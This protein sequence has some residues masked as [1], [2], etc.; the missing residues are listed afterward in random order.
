[1]KGFNLNQCA[2]RGSSGTKVSSECAHKKLK[3]DE[4]FTTSFSNGSLIVDI[5]QRGDMNQKLHNGGASPGRQ[6]GVVGDEVST[7]SKF[8]KFKLK[9]GGVTRTI[10]AK[11][12]CHATSGNGSSTKIAEIS[13]STRPLPKPILQDDFDEGGSPLDKSCGMQGIPWK[14]FSR[15]DFNHLN[16]IPTGKMRDKNVSRKQAEKSDQVR[17]NK[18][19]SRKC[20]FN[21]EFDDDDDEIRYLEKLRTSK[22]AAVS[23]DAVQESG[24]KEQSRTKD[25][26]VANHESAKAFGPSR[27]D[28]D[29]K[30]A[31]LDRVRED[32]D[33][34]EEKIMH[35]GEPECKQKRTGKDVINSP[36]ESKKGI[37]LSMRQRALV[38]GKGFSSVA[39]GNSIEFPNGLPP[40]PS[41]RKKEKL[42]E[43]EQQLKKAETAERRRMQREKAAR[44]S[45]AEAI[46]KILGQ[47]SSRK[48]REDKI[49]KRQEELAQVF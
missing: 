36:A 27:W 10:E 38:S 14:D 41:R 31:K 20:E 18:R 49:K 40:P 43:V 15:R 12:T 48:K 4:G 16:V 19:V 5:E 9:V 22:V 8:K 39:G 25:L 28:T 21:G 7:K 23:K 47:D 17:K 42:T 34:E 1:M 33:Y 6:Q 2:V 26:K 44:E 13:D 30:K 35:E 11:P 37:A 24:T 3:G 46:R 45:E 32:T 29:G